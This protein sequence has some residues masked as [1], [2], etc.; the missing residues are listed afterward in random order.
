MT[1]Y[2]NIKGRRIVLAAPPFC[3]HLHPILAI[4]IHLRELGAECVVVTGPN[5]QGVVERCDLR[6]YPLL[7]DRPN[8]L[9]S[10]ADTD[11]PMTFNPL[12]I[13]RQ[14]SENIALMPEI[15][16]QATPLFDAFKPDV[17]ISDFTAFPIN[18]LANQLGIPHIS[19]TPTPLAIENHDGTPSYLGGW[20]PGS[21]RLCALRDFAG[22]KLIRLA[23]TTIA[24]P[25]QRQ[26][27]RIGVRVY[28]KD[29]TESI[30]SSQ[31]TLGLGMT[32]LE[33]PRTWP[34]YFR[35][36]G[37]LPFCPE[38]SVNLDLR[39]LS[40]RPLV[41]VTAGTHVWW[42]KRR[43]LVD[44]QKLREAN[45]DVHFIYSLGDSKNVQTLPIE[46]NEAYTVFPYVPYDQH[47]KF[48]RAI[49]H[50]GGSGVMYSCIEQGL[51]ALVRPLDYDQFDYAARIQHHK[52]GVRVKSYNSERAI[53]AL[54]QMLERPDDFET[55]RF[56]SRLKTYKP[57]QTVAEE[58]QRLMKMSN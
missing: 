38:R 11:K 16:K 46:H 42:A 28:R 25:F 22:R 37:P 34:S 13:Y 21:G 47:L 10:I 23:K 5:K 6:P 4:G 26:L 44:T 35:M 12:T 9:E 52:L 53:V 43:L 36:I 58:V 51:P 27:N 33:F 17:V 56:Q 57:L 50:H 41:F 24:F 15:M 40:P 3:G 54:R 14:I 49:L 2:D 45:P 29:G 55:G 7:A 18:H 30:Y 1:F 20:S 19:V 39:K 48:F 31:S 32:E 8:I